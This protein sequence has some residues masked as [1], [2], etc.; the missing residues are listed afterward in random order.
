MTRTFPN[1]V[2]LL[3]VLAL[4][5]SLMAVTVLPASAAAVTFHSVTATPTT[6]ATQAGYSFCFTPTTALTVGDTIT[7]TF[8][9]G[10]TLPSSIS[11]TYISM[12]GNGSA[13][14][15]AQA[16]AADPQIS[17][18]QLI[19]QVPPSGAVGTSGNSTLRISQAAGI[20]N[21]SIAYTAAEL[22]YQFKLVT[23]KDTTQATAYAGYTPSVTISPTYGDRNTSVTVTGKGWRP[24]KSI[25][26]GTALLGSGV[27]NADGSFSITAVPQTSGNVSCRD[28][29]G[30]GT[31]NSGAGTLWTQ[32][33]CE[34]PDFT[35]QARVTVSPTSVRPGAQV[36]VYG[37][38]FTAS[39]NI[40]VNGID[41]GGTNWGPSAADGAVT[42]SAI[43]PYPTSGTADDFTKTLTCRWD[44]YGAQE[45]LVTDSSA[46][47]AKA[48]LTVAT[49]TVTVEPSTA[50]P[51]EWV[52]VSG[53][54]FPA[55]VTI[56]SG[57]LTLGGTAWSTSDIV[58]SAEGTW[59]TQI[60]VLSAAKPGVNYIVAS[61]LNATYGTV[62]ATTTLTVGSR[63]IT[64]TPAS[65]PRGTET[66]VTATNMTIAGSTIA[67]GG[68]YPAAGLYFAQNDWNTSANGGG[69]A[70]TVTS[71]GTLSPTALKVPATGGVVGSNAIYAMDA[72]GATAT[73]TFTITQPTMTASK[74]TGSKGDTIT[75]TGAGW[76]PGELG[77]ITVT[78][79]P[80]GGT[81]TTLFTTTPLGD[82]TWTSQ[83]AIPLTAQATNTI[84]ATD[85][86]NNAATSIVF[87][88]DTASISVDPSS[89][90]V[91]TEVVVSGEGFTP[92]TGFTTFT[93][94][95]VAMSTVGMVTD[96]LGS[97]SATVTIPGLAQGSKTITVVIGADTATTFF[98][99]STAA[100]S[101]NVQTG[102]IASQLVR[103]WGY[104]PTDGW[105]MY[106]PADATGSDL[107]SMVDG[108]GYW[109]KVTEDV[110]LV[111]LGKSRALYTGW[112]NIGW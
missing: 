33:Q 49:P 43:D 64:C 37:W 20:V 87:K 51:N 21:P 60:R 53:S 111:Y 48:T 95:G 2:R 86:Y 98:Q 96:S 81:A 39:G 91:G 88:L 11:K 5:C 63:S 89:G 47:T 6:A 41:L 99:V 83:F 72:A 38:D 12:A 79:T 50:A 75:L 1:L 92:Q 36:T 93:V 10:V 26:I 101:I 57:N 106:D 44:K 112:N 27:S 68:T 74:T 103:V 34:E 69:S 105:K 104:T 4:V 42:L 97:F 100:V 16:T 29:S 67:T 13:N 17:G 56:D 15:F 66:T 78:L 28:G 24:D 3:V 84:A 22:A 59:S 110:T 85:G 35:L 9:A 77:R 55:S 58:A 80:A 109:V 52:T 71:G 61:D 25:T 94:G 23:S 73:G 65:G 102:S 31:A 7:I 70:I 8:P 82:G 62:T 14:N 40:P 32:A 18:Q 30:R 90:P 76:V 108:A 45:V 54:N 46:K 19:I 107:G